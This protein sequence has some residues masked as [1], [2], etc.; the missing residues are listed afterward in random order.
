MRI[1]PGNVLEHSDRTA[2]I[3]L[4]SQ[5]LAINPE[6][7]YNVANLFEEHETAFSS[8]LA[9]RGLTMRGLYNNSTSPDFQVIGN[10]QVKW[11]VKGRSERKAR[12]VSNNSAGSTPGLSHATFVLTLDN[13]WFTEKETLLCW[14]VRT[15]LYV[16]E[17]V[18]S[19]DNNWNYTVQ[20]MGN[21]PNAFVDPQLIIE[22][23][24]LS[25][26]YTAYPE[27][28]EDAS[29]R[30][31]HP[32]WH[33]E[34]MTIQRWK[35]SITGSA[36]ASKMLIEHKGKHLFAEYQ[37]MEMLHRMMISRERQ[38]LFGRASVDSTGNNVGVTDK[39]NRPIIAGN[40]LIHQGDP[41]MKFTYTD[42][43]IRWLENLIVQ[44]QLSSTSAG[45]ASEIVL[46]GGL[47]FMTD[48]HRTMRSLF[49]M[50]P[51]VFDEGSGEN[52]GA[53]GSPFGYYK[54]N[55]VKIVP[56][57][58]KAFDDPM[59]AQ[60]VDGYG[61]NYRSRMG[62]ALNTGATLSGQ[63]PNIKLLA[64]GNSQEDRRYIERELVGMTGGGSKNV[65][66]GRLMVSS[67]VDAYEV[68]SI[69]E[70]GIALMNPLSFVE[71]VPA[72]RR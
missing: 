48:F 14:D 45:G 59:G 57:W 46:G 38:L 3:P 1:V 42:M 68:H 20:L 43:N 19:T 36:K 64:L 53:N 39:D 24:E 52:R 49:E 71:I 32:E 4:L 54:F 34:W 70:T 8:F 72:I 18:K 37:H 16:R 13:D 5:A 41:S 35:Y 25:S 44:M 67:S 26:G 55:G 30:Y 15:V 27:G 33:T 40:G 56:I 23:S 63:N 21:D 66:T 11:A 28:S 51:V 6:V 29:E 47:S 2:S 62:F 12:I 17:K 61:V 22:G 7:F 10:R 31:T 58:I 69:C 9:R 65:Q 60:R 50:N